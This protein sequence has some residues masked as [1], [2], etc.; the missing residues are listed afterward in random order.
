ML[1]KFNHLSSFFVDL[2]F[3]MKAI[4]KYRTR[5]KKSKEKDKLTEKG[6]ISYKVTA[7]VGL[8]FLDQ[9]KFLLIFLLLDVTV[10]V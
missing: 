3:E 7:W 2:Y 8:D 9:S 4:K 10:S 1:I 5:K 6:K